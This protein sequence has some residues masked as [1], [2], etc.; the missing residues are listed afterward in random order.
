MEMTIF[1]PEVKTGLA[2]LTCFQPVKVGKVSAVINSTFPGRIWSNGMI[3]G[4]RLIS[5]ASS[6]KK[7]NKKPFC[8]LNTLT[9]KC[10]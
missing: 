6:V 2:W 5:D 3:P 7:K 1:I 4:Q 8:S 9:A 10:F